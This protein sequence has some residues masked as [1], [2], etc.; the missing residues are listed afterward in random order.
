ME[1]EL[2]EVLGDVELRDG[3]GQLEDPRRGLVEEG[4]RC[5]GGVVAHAGARET[6]VP[7]RYLDTQ[8]SRSLT[9]THHRRRH[10]KAIV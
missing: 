6:N 8:G 5:E 3:E 10:R 7:P 9:L 1:V 4:P 2:V